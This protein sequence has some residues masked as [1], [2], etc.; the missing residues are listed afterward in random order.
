MKKAL[1]KLKKKFEGK[2][3]MYWNNYPG[4]S[5]SGWRMYIKVK[6]ITDNRNCRTVSFEREADGTKTFKSMN[7]TFVNMLGR[8]C[9]P[10][11]NATFNAAFY[12]FKE[13]IR[14]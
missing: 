11:T 2:C 5:G 6:K 12:R 8:E 9:S 13:T 3:F 1:T 10:I 7:R 4:S 14:I